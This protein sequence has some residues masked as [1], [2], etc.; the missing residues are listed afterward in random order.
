MKNLVDIESVEKLIKEADSL[1]I[2][3]V[4]GG[5]VYLSY[6]YDLDDLTTLDLL[7]YVTAQLYEAAEEGPSHPHKL[8]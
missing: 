3:S 6:S 2:I 8:N 1:A 5:S 7:A 4:S